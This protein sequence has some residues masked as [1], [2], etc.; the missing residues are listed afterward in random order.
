MM[1]E[2]IEVRDRVRNKGAG[3]FRGKQRTSFLLGIRKTEAV[4][5]VKRT[6]KWEKLK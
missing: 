4:H 2:S 3:K 1:V 5:G 6:S